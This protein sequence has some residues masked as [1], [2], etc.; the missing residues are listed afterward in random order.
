MKF[1]IQL[2]YLVATL[3]AGQVFAVPG[4]DALEDSYHPYHPSRKG[5]FSYCGD[6]TPC[7]CKGFHCGGT[8]CT[9]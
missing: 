9:N 2:A 5:C 4:A 6:G 8:L 1:S 3:F 7:A